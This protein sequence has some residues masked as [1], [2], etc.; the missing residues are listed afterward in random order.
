MTDTPFVIAGRT[1]RSR[2]IVGT[3]KYS[4]PAVMVQAHDASGADMITVAVRRV[5]IFDRNKESL[6]DYIDRMEKEHP[7]DYITVVLPEFV[8]KHWW[9]HLLHNQSALTLKAALLFRPRVV[10]TSVPFHLSE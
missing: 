9:H 5:N 4:S 6:L 1:F 8:V 7:D 3:G 2:L 10:T